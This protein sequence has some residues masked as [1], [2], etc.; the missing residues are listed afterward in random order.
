MDFQD[1]ESENHEYADLIADNRIV[2]LSFFDR[3]VLG[4]ILAELDKNI[5][6]ELTGFEKGEIE[7]FLQKYSSDA[8]ELLSQYI[9]TPP[10]E[11]GLHSTM[12]TDEE[13]NIKKYFKKPNKFEFFHATVITRKYPPGLNLL[14]TFY[15]A[16]NS[17]DSSAQYP[18]QYANLLFRIR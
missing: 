11:M 17:E 10:G 1:Y 16:L 14:I 4:E 13:K 7:E 15:N 5:E 18:H 9:Q 8:E 2:E 3:D 6:I 12:N